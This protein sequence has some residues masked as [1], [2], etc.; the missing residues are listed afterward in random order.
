MPENSD[1]DG[2]GTG[3]RLRIALNVPGANTVPVSRVLQLKSDR[4]S[5]AAVFRITPMT[6]GT[7]ALRFSVY[8]ELDAQM[9]QEVEA[10]LLVLDAVGEGAQIVR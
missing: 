5:S 8:L 1:S 6:A 2:N 10:E 4:T 7:L 3:T 9:L